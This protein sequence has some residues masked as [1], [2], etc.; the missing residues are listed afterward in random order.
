MGGVDMKR[1]T[2][3]RGFYKELKESKR[4]M[5]IR[6]IKRLHTVDIALCNDNREPVIRFY[7]YADS[8]DEFRLIRKL[9]DKHNDLEVWMRSHDKPT[10]RREKAIYKCRMHGIPN[11]TEL[12]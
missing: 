2:Q 1:T 5:G 12:M 7:Y 11:I 4:A 3:P 6:K 8:I 10:T 9:W